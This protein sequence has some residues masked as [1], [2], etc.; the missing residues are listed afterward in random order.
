MT[1]QRRAHSDFMEVQFFESL[2]TVQF[3]FKEVQFRERCAPY[4]VKSAQLDMRKDHIKRIKG[5]L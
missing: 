3:V 1:S 4:A 2:G 5:K